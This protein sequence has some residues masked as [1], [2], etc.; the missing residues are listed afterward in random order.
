LENRTRKCL[1]EIVLRHMGFVAFRLHKRGFP[2][3]VRRYGEDLLSESIP[4]LYRHI[5][6]YDLEYR[7]SEG[8]PRPVKFATYIWKR[9]D[10]FIID[11][12]R[13]EMLREKTHCEC[14]G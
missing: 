10:G 13:K 4:I 3:F 1:N 11:F 12:L 9:I 2:E 8:R 5:K 7:D 14:D 6:S